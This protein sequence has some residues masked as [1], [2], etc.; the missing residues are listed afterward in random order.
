MVEPKRD[1]ERRRIVVEDFL[2]HDAFRA[3]LRTQLRG[4]LTSSPKRVSPI[5]FYDDAGSMLFD[6][7]TR[8]PEYYLT[9]AERAILRE[10]APAIA[11]RTGAETLVELGS[12]TSEKT[13]LLLNAMRST[14]RLRRFVPVD[15]SEQTLRDAANAVAERYPALEVRGIVGD[16]HRHLRMIP[17]DGVRMV[18][19]LGSTVGNLMPAERHRFFTDLDSAL[20]STDW[21]LVGTDLVKDPTVLEA[22]YNDSR[23]VTAEF[24]LNLLRVLNKEFSANFDLDSF[25]HVAVWNADERWIEMRLRSLRRQTVSVGELGLELGFDAG[26]ELWTE[27]SAKFDPE[28]VRGELWAAGFV[29][30]ETFTD[31]DGRF[32]LT[33]AHPY[34]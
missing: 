24:N 13:P 3:E 20:W 22:A 15:V 33:L 8:L 34:C 6:E 5:W 10:H 28:Q 26:E 7:I 17:D 18:A 11:A 30:D 23:G 4:G 32:M 16:F 21:F 2:D 1:G 27:I 25:E 19:F 9:R 14:G 29:T 12:G 31:D